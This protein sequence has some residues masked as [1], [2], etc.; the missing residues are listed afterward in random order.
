MKTG[1]KKHIQLRKRSENYTPGSRIYKK[2]MG[3]CPNAKAH[4]TRQHINLNSFDSNTPDRAGGINGDLKNPRWLWR[5]SNQIL[6]LAIF[7]T[8]AHF[9]IYNQIGLNLNVIINFLFGSLPAL[10]YFIF[11]WNERIERFYT[12]AK[13]PIVHRVTKISYIR[14]LIVIVLFALFMLL[15]Y[16]L[17]FGTQPTLFGLSILLFLMWGFYFQLFYWEKKNHMKIY[18]KNESGFQ[19]TY[20]LGEKEG[21]L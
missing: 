1:S 8:I 7:L 19:K 10:F 14:G 3:W 18:I 6:L 13:K 15:P 4:E 12:I 21:E 2:L 20:A 5:V 9:L 17:N 16:M 11:H